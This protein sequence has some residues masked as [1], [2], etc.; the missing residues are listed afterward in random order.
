MDEPVIELTPE[1]DPTADEA[2]PTDE[3][4]I[5]DEPKLNGYPIIGAD[6]IDAII[7]E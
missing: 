6:I 5:E 4:D 2:I 1:T 7:E 3:D